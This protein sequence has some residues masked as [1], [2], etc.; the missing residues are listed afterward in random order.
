ML[1]SKK[2]QAI[3]QLVLFSREEGAEKG[4]SWWEI[5]EKADNK[6]FVGLPNEKAVKNVFSDLILIRK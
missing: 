5:K 3:A 2:K 4:E 6:F 1:F